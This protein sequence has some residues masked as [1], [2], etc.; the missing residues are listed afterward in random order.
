MLTKL[1]LF[2]TFFFFLSLFKM[3]RKAVLFRH[4]SLAVVKGKEKLNKRNGKRDLI[5][6]IRRERELFYILSTSFS[7]PLLFFVFAKEKKSGYV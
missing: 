7:R 4:R 1:F 6:D 5:N 2:T 3:T